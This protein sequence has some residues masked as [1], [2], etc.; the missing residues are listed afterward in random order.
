MAD[1]ADPGSTPTTLAYPAAGRTTPRSALHVV[2]LDGA[3]PVEITWDH[4]ALPYLVDVGWSAA[5]PLTVTVQSRDQR[6]LV[7]LAAD[8]DH[9]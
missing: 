4:D 5:G 2:R 3:A 6:R 7:V 8:A 9:R 1:A